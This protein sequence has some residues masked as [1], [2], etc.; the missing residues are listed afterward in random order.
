MIISVFLGR[1]GF[2]RTEP[3]P[4]MPSGVRS[5]GGVA[6]TPASAAAVL[7]GFGVAVAFG[8]FVGDG[9]ALGFGVALARG[10]GLG[11]D[12]VLASAR[13]GSREG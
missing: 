3:P 9:V 6:L 11:G 4:A 1:K 8:V 10:V 13:T 5:V 7:A 2:G 12:D